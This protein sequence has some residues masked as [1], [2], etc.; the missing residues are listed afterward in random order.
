MGGVIASELKPREAR[1]GS[2]GVLAGEIA[3]ERYSNLKNIVRN[4]IR[5]N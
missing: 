5:P 2:K 4:S 3:T 1:D